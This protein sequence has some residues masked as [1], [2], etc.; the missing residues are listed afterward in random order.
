[1]KERGFTL[2]ELL[3]SLV[4]LGVVTSAALQVVIASQ[5]GFEWHAASA[6]LAANMRVAISLIPDELRGLDAGDPL[7]SDIVAARPSSISY[8]VTR[9]LYFACRTPT[10]GSNVVVVD[11]RFRLGMRG[12]DPAVDS[13]LIYSESD[14]RSTEDDRWLHAKVESVRASQDCPG[15]RPGITLQVSNVTA[16]GLA[17]VR[18]GA[19]VRAFE[20][21]RLHLYRDS[22]GDWWLGTKRYR[23]ASGG[24]GGRGGRG[25]WT[26]TQPVVGPLTDSGIHFKYLNGRG[27]ETSDRAGIAR[28]SIA[29]TGRSQYRVH[30]S[31]GAVD[32]LTD[33]LSTGVQLRNNPIF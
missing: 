10:P 19:P 32:F 8:K 20:L 1:M 5:R 17:S 12:I 30:T 16:P 27:E 23:I 21:N 13:L 33:R 9:S 28:I 11:A 2:V 31:G 18:A 22:G 7:G 25:G 14:P 29:V 4:L 26:R 15:R 6:D 3:V 24:R